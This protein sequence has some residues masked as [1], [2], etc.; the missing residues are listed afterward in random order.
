[1][2][3]IVTKAVSAFFHGV[4]VGFGAFVGFIVCVALVLF[5]WWSVIVTSLGSVMQKAVDSVAPPPLFRDEFCSLIDSMRERGM[6]TAQIVHHTGLSPEQ[7]S[8]CGV[9]K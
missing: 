2:Q 9:G 3:S 5:L 8:R 1:M 7:L 4:C 6:T